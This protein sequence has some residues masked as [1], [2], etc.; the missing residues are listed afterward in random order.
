LFDTLGYVWIQDFGY[1]Y[2]L[3]TLYIRFGCMFDTLLSVFEHINILQSAPASG[4][5]AEDEGDE[6]QVGVGRRL[7]D[8][9]PRTLGDEGPEG[10]ER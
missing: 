7:R 8:R 5:W 6:R 3:D 2:V 1:G 10:S 4:P 9:V